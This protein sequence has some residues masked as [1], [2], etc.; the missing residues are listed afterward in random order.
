MVEM[1]GYGALSLLATAPSGCAKSFVLP[2]SQ[3]AKPIA[4]LRLLRRTCAGS[5]P[6]HIHN[7]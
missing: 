6:F 4:V 7:K 5:H 2:T 3:S 1:T